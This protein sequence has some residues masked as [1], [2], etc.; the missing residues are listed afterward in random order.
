MAG[1]EPMEESTNGRV[2]W[3]SG[4]R[5]EQAPAKDSVW[6]PRR[7]RPDNKENKPHPSQSLCTAGGKRP[8]ESNYEHCP[9]PQSF[10]RCGPHHRAELCILE[11][12]DIR[13][14]HKVW[15]KYRD[16]LTWPW[17]EKKPEL[18]DE[19][20]DKFR[21]IAQKVVDAMVEEY[22]EPM[23]L[24]QATIS[25][26]NHVG[27]PPHSD[28]VQFDS[29]W[30]KGKRIRAED[31]VAAAQ[32]GAY[33]LWRSEKT[34]YRSYGCTVSLT[35]PNNFEGGEVQFFEKFGDR[36]PVAT[37]KCAEGCGVA[38]CGCQR[39]IHAVTSVRSGFRLVLLVWTRPP[40]VKVAESQAHVCYF[41]PG[42]G[43]GVWLTTGDML[44]KQ[45]KRR[46]CEPQ[47]AWVPCEADDGSCVCPKCVVEREKLAWKDRFQVAEHC[48]EV[49]PNKAPTTPTTSAGNS[50]R[51]S[52]RSPDGS[53][54][55][56]SREGSEEE[57][58]KAEI[59][60]CPHA[61]GVVRC[62]DHDPKEMQDILDSQE[63]RQ[64]HVLW[65]KHR[66]D[67]SHPWYDKKP[68]FTPSEFDTFR[69]IAQ[70]VV[71]AMVDVYEQPL[72]LDQATI[73]CTNHLG[74]PPHADNVQFDSV[75]WRGRK[76]RQRDEVMAAR[77]GAEVL[78][79]GVKTNYRNYG[80]SIALTNPWQYGGG[81]FELY[82]KWADAEPQKKFRLNQGNGISCCGCQNGIH[83]VT[84]VKWGFRLV[85][86]V[87]TR[88]PD[89]PVPA[90][91]A[92]V[93]YFRPGTGQSVWLTTADLQNYPRRRTEESRN[94]CE[95]EEEDEYVQDQ[96]QDEE[97]QDKDQIVVA[98]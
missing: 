23:V 94:P 37:Y 49:D 56:N 41:R 2:G 20:Y 40:H 74:H 1:K 55:S 87:W 90:D 82:G 79:K 26:S 85:L 77:G 59:S 76:V 96:E 47:Q 78:W 21:E 51:T 58:S 50:P 53:D 97:L 30:W 75:W 71:D 16:D 13:W 93:C 19:D 8:Q 32:D 42:T 52:E 73:S 34:S 5:E 86:L 10:V 63:V 88:S 18:S 48:P 81:D 84:S 61:Q 22:K 15:S 35:N 14:L 33:V 72:V 64:L 45:A 3:K 29:V 46:G 36:D 28:N 24:D 31:E 65:K 12:P 43:M 95:D 80:A 27:H 4:R 70:K 89:V 98:A 92:H 62:L 9:T 69:A 17:Y 91:Q 11:K 68:E 39:N 44:R 25:N 38:F 60:H 66:D 83:A 7:P 57:V 6:F 67:L 54:A